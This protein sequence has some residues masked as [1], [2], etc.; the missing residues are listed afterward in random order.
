MEIKNL[1]AEDGTHEPWVLE[2]LTPHYVVV[3][4]HL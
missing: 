1:E 4:A 3:L 2:A